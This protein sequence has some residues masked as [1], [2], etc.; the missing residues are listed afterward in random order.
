M[1]GWREGK[2]RIM[3]TPVGHSLAG[4]FLYRALEQTGDRSELNL[5]QIRIGFCILMANL[6][7]IDYLPGL[8]LGNPHAF[9]HGPTHSLAFLLCAWV[10][11]FLVGPNLGWT[12]ARAA[13]LAG[14]CVL[15]H[16]VMDCLTSD[17]KA[18]YGIP[19]LWPWVHT[20]VTSPVSLFLPPAK[21]SFKD[22]FQF[23]NILVILME[24]LLFSP[25]LYFLRPSTRQREPGS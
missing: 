18:P 16:L 10:L 13:W 1:A 25:I 6:P 23:W 4:W 9:H 17:M 12:R 2:G 8:I 19:L 5:R 24:F 22:L 20:S 21:S 11:G 15:S 3:A 7:D 14:L